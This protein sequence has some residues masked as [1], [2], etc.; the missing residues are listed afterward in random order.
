MPAIPIITAVVSAVGV[1][2]SISSANSAK[3]RANKQADLARRQAA[4]QNQANAQAMTTA[5]TRD[6]IAAE[7]EANQALA[8][9]QMTS[10]VDAQINVP[11]TAGQR[12]RTQ[13]AQF[14]TEGEDETG[15]LRI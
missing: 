13:R 1:A 10:T 2:S 6:R 7:V 9:E 4:V 11:E 5:N 15:A 3:K 12:R 8:N 14:R